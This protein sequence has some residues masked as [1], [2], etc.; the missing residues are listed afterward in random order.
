MARRPPLPQSLRQKLSTLSLSPSSPASSPTTLRGNST[1]DWSS[2]R[3]P[4]I[5]KK[6]SFF[7]WKRDGEDSEEEE[8]PPTQE[9]IERVEAVLDKIICQAGVDYETRPMVV[10]TAAALPDPRAVSYDLLLTRI[11]AHLD[12]YVENDYTVVFL[13]AGGRH[14]PGW[15][16]VWKAYRSLS[17]KENLKHEREII[18]PAEQQTN[19]FGV[20]LEILMGEYGENGG[21]PRVVKD[22]VEFV[23]ECGMEVEGIFRRSPNSALLK[24]AKE[25][26]DRGHPVSL[27]AFADPHIAAV[28]LKKFFRDL[29]DPIFHED[30]YPVVRKCPMPT[31]DSGDMA[32]IAYIREQILPALRTDAAEILLSYVF[33]LLHDISIRSSTNLM[34]AHNLAVCFCPTLVGSN[35][36]RDLQMCTIPGGPSLGSGLSLLLPN[37]DGKTT[38]GMVVKIC[39]ERYFE[40][41]E[42]V[43]DRSEPLHSPNATALSQPER[44]LEPPSPYCIVGEGEDESLDD[45]MLVMPVGP[46]SPTHQSPFANLGSPRSPPTAW[47]HKHRRIGSNGSNASAAPTP[48]AASAAGSTRSKHRGPGSIGGHSHSKGRTSIVSIE[49]ALGKAGARGSIAMGK[50]SMR[51]PG[52]AGVEAVSVTA[53]GFFMPPSDDS[54]PT[55]DPDAKDVDTQ[56]DEI[57]PEQ[58][59][60][61]ANGNGGQQSEVAE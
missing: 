3:S 13:T 57:S 31:S 46:T 15:N 41:F 10:I 25:A 51:K 58:S 52:G 18:L 39:I 61:T 59:A 38:V 55:N 27:S 50:G 53:L 40:I 23:R 35:P 5:R 60:V 43:V 49:K 21:I 45:T 1:S 24:Q 2:T 28:L 56:Q 8:L 26:Y 6:G 14:T 29:P 4:V 44:D 16:W 19:V 32:T 12:A 47:R 54:L 22:C 37:M 20:P 11:L 48:S 17:R 7:N 30:M 36:A 33:H 34:N 9:D 42:E